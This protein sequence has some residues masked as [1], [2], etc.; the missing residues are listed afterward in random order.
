MIEARGLTKAFDGF[1][2]VTGLDLKIGPGEAYA[3]LGPLGC[4]NSSV[5]KM[6]ATLVPPTRGE[7]LIAGEDVRRRPDSV[8]R[9]VGYMPDV[10][11]V[12]DDMRVDECLGFF[13]RGH[14]LEETAAKKRIAELLALTGLE[15]AAGQYVESLGREHRQRL[16]LARALLHSPTILLL[17]KPAAGLDLEARERFFTIIRRLREPTANAPPLTI[18]MSSNVLSDAMALCERIG[19]MLQGKLIA[20]GPSGEIVPKLA[21]HRIFEAQIADQAAAAA[22]WLRTQTMVRHAAAHGGFLIFTLLG[23]EQPCDLIAKLK[24]QGYSVI[25]WR[26]HEIDFDSLV[27]PAI[28]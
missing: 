1:P 26:E 28:T 15:E 23:R 22:A 3:L 27:T 20:D 14:G 17:D 10:M 11:G 5:I 13:A 12:Y 24:F 8:R 7:A 21:P 6:M 4:G 16:G 19:V 2:A 9:L 25:H 18:L